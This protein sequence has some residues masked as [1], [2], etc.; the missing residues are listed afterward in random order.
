MKYYAYL[1]QK[2]EGCDYMIGCGSRLVTINANDDTEARQKLSELVKED[3]VGEQELAK[4]LLFKDIIDFDLK[5][6]Y[7][8][9]NQK[10]NSE[11]SRM[12]HLKDMEE[13]NR[14]KGKLGM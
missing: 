14:L 6:V 10:K 4:V 1:K 7:D 11:K 2:G 5:G 12:Q 3:Y 13:F 8:E 9:Y